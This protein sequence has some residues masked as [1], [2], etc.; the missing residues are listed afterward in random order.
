MLMQWDLP[1]AQKAVFNLGNHPRYIGIFFCFILLFYF[2]HAFFGGLVYFAL[3]IIVGVCALGLTHENGNIVLNIKHPKVEGPSQCIPQRYPQHNLPKELEAPLLLL[4]TKL[5]HHYIHGWYSHVSSDMSFVKEVENT[6]GYIM[7]NFYSYLSTQDSS[8]LI[9]EMLKN[10]LNTLTL[11]LS[12]LNVFLSKKMP[13]A[14]FAVRYPNSAVAKM[15]DKA[16]NEQALRSQ[17][18]A[19]ITKFCKSEDAACLPLHVL[20]REVLAMQVFKKITTH[21]AKPVFVNRCI[22][23]CLSPSKEKD[24]CISRNRYI[25]RCLLNKTL[26]DS[27]PLSTLPTDDSPQTSYS[28]NNALFEAEIH[29]QYRSLDAKELISPIKDKKNLKFIITVHSSYLDI[30]PWIVYRTYSS[31]KSMYKDLRKEFLHAT[32]APLMFPRWRNQTYGHFRQNLSAYL[33][34]I[35][36]VPKLSNDAVV[37]HFFCKSLSFQPLPDDIVDGMERQNNSSFST[38]SNKILEVTRIV[39]GRSGHSKTSE[40]SSTSEPTWN[41]KFERS[42]LEDTDLSNIPSN[43]LSSM[44]DDNQSF[45]NKNEGK[46]HSRCSSESNPFGDEPSAFRIQEEALKEIIDSGFALFGELSCLNPKTWFFRRTVLSVLK[47]LLL[48]GPVDVSG[49]VEK[50]LKD[51]VFAKLSNTQL[52]GDFFTSLILNIWPEEKEKVQEH[53]RNLQQAKAHENEDGAN[54]DSAPGNKDDTDLY[55]EEAMKNSLFNSH[56][57]FAVQQKNEEQMRVE[58]KELFLN[59]AYADN[60]SFLGPLTSGDSLRVLFDL[61]QESDLVEGFLAHVLSNALHSII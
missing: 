12:D 34:G 8:Y 21:C 47:S 15:L 24:E 31:L 58:A 9:F 49:I 13:I 22:I 48:Y 46:N 54:W 39:S 5:T 19:M 60:A 44:E 45:E 56:S 61:L 3:G 4:I 43:E 29:I 50:M 41:T 57:A 37:R 27:S 14:E 23:L 20:L 36:Q 33:N 10:V 52:L 1:T 55:L 26:K 2:F 42:M 51:H 40:D 11:L 53:L 16:A 32:G 18:S 35:V 7:R 59:N 30:P 6:I 17:A 28:F 25:N 38:V